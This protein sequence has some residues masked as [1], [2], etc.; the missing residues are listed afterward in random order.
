[1]AE[2]N[3]LWRNGGIHYGAVAELNT[4]WRNGGIKYIM[5]QWRN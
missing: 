3:T 4:L 2:L 5:A 1:M